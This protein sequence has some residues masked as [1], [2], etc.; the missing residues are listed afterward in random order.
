MTSAHDRYL[1]ARETWPATVEC[2][3]CGNSFDATY[4]SEYGQGSLEPEECPKCHRSD[5]LHVFPMDDADISERRY[6]TDNPRD[7]EL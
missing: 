1:M 7:L 5:N 6:G 3:D 4:T 2:D